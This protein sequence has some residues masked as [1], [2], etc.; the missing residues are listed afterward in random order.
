MNTVD[1][2]LLHHHGFSH[3]KSWLRHIALSNW[4]PGNDPVATVVA[5]LCI[6]REDYLLELEGLIKEDFNPFDVSSPVS[7]PDSLDGNSLS[8][9][10][11]YFFRNSLKSLNEIRNSAERLFVDREHKGGL[12][13]ETL[14][15]RQALEVLRDEIRGLADV[16]KDLRDRIGGHVLQKGVR[17][18]LRG[19]DPGRN[20][21]LEIGETRAETHYPFAGY[22]TLAIMFP[23]K[24]EEVLLVELQDLFDKT[25]NLIFIVGSIDKII[26]A[27]V[28]GRGLLK[29]T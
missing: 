5:R 29:K 13:T 22:I 14:E 26:D 12:A 6:L 25:A 3:R 10:R 19:T 28:V 17:D 15:L 11:L 1:E 4:F 21:L 20:A 18:A 23:G 16:I 8:W 7:K 24:S 2:Y 27:Y 9:R